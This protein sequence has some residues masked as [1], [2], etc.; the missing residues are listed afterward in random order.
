MHYTGGSIQ[1]ERRCDVG[2]V[3]ALDDL[4]QPLIDKLIARGAIEPIDEAGKQ[5]GN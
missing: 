5:D 1:S 3:V 4:P 2:D